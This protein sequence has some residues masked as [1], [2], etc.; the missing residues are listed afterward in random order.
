MTTTL[1]GENV[2]GRL[3][4]ILMVKAQDRIL[5]RTAVLPVPKRSS[6]DPPR[7]RIMTYLFSACQG[8]SEAG[9]AVKEGIFQVYYSSDFGDPSQWYR[10]NFEVKQF[11]DLPA[12]Q[13]RK[14][15][16]LLEYWQANNRE[17]YTEDE[18]AEYSQEEFTSTG[19]MWSLWELRTMR[20]LHY[21]RLYGIL[22][23]FHQSKDQNSWAAETFLKR[24]GGY[25]KTIWKEWTALD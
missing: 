2:A 18:V 8:R 7:R 25:I 12:E 9:G 4:S 20:M 15:E 3:A 22:E 19:H 13:D 10:S 17:F 21:S 5:I 11:P 23:G 1:T 6:N 16:D 24:F 14:M